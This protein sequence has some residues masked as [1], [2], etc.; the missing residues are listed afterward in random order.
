MDYDPMQDVQNAFQQQQQ[1]V[2]T[3]GPRGTMPPPTPQQGRDSDVL[4]AMLAMNLH[5]PQQAALLRQQMQ[6]DRLRAMA[7]G[8]MKSSSSIGTPNVMGNIAAVAAAYKANQ[9]DKQAQTGMED[10]GTKRAGLY[11]KLIGAL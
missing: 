8:M 5:N 11:D 1:Q 9:L 10:L 3:M 4:K 2:P 6:A 7:P